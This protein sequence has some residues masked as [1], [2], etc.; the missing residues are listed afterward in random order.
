MK[1]ARQSMTIW[2][3]IVSALVVV[4]GALSL[5]LGAESPDWTAFAQTSIGAA[6][7]ALTA[8]GGRVRKG[9]GGSVRRED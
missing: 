2:G 8:I 3:A 6:I 4:L 1:R 7:V 9:G 5:T